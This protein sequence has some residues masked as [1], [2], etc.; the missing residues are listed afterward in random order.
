VGGGCKFCATKGINLAAPSVIYLIT[1]SSLNAHKIG[2]SA[3]SGYRLRQHTRLGWEVFKTAALPTGEDA[4]EVESEVL[5]WLRLDLGLPAYLSSDD[6][7]KEA[8]PKRFV[9]QRRLA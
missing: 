8:G 2:I 7:P 5:R 6:M 4:F 1:H 9:R 3:P